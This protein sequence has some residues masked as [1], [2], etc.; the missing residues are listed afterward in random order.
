MKVVIGYGLLSC[1]WVQLS[2]ISLESISSFERGSV[3]TLLSLLPASWFCN[4]CLLCCVLKLGEGGSGFVYNSLAQ[5]FPWTRV[6][7]HSFCLCSPGDP[8][9]LIQAAVGDV[10]AFHSDVRE[11]SVA[12]VG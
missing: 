1:S 11:N 5:L 2:P 10:T 12:L 8:I 4:H 7:F 6:R 9:C 3:G